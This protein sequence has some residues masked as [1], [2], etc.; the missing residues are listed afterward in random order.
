M[1]GIMLGP[2]TKIHVR[3]AITIGGGVGAFIAMSRLMFVVLV[4][5]ALT[6]IRNIEL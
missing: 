3:S 2:R 1:G 6:G 4:W 5:I